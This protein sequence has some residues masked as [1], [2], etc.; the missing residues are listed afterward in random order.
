MKV[1]GYEIEPYANLR[2][3]DLRGAD[4]KGADLKGADL[5]G[6]HLKGADLREADLREAYLTGAHLSGAHL[7]GAHLKGA[8]LSWAYLR[9]ADLREAYLREAD[10]REA[11]LSGVKLGGAILPD[12]KIVPEEGSFVGFKKLRDGVICKL[13]IAEDAKRVSTLV[14]RK[15]RASRVIVLEG[16]GYSFF[17]HS[18]FYIKGKVVTPVKPFNEDI[19]IECASGIHFFIT[20]EEAEKY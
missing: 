9:G 6:A 12:Y 15:C 18:V 4:L 1:N 17:D 16:V 5:R 10:L 7:K 14:G 19:R 3:A 11:D 8:D 20:R 2:W 13:L